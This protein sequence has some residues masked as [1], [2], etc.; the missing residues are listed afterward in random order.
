MSGLGPALALFDYAGLCLFALT[1]ALAAAEKQQ[2]PVTFAFFSTAT[3]VGGGT[4]RDLLIGVPV[5]WV[6]DQI[7]LLLCLAMAA[8]VWLTDVG[9]WPKR[10]ILWLDAVG[11]GAYATVGAAKALSAGVGPL[12]AIVM[13][14]FTA[15]MGGVIRD[16][17]AHQPSTILG[18]EIYITAAVVAATAYVALAMIGVP[19]LVAA[20]AGGALGFGLRAAAIARGWELP[21]YR[22][23]GEKH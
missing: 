5:F 2:T 19:L 6:S 22:R 12:I 4:I 23:T 16:V 21:H 15:A 7:A 11:L 9:R 3:G 17:L 8:L 18:P 13:G 14:V 20:I 10:S 1:G